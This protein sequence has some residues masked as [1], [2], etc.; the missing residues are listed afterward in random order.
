MTNLLDKEWEQS[1][2]KA[3]DSKFSKIYHSV[4]FNELDIKRYCKKDSK[5]LEIGCGNG[6]NLMKLK[7]IGYEDIWG[8]DKVNQMKGPLSL[9]YLDYVHTKFDVI[10]YYETL[11]HIDTTLTELRK[12][13]SYLRPGGYLFICEPADNK[14]LGLQYWLFNLKVLQDISFIRNVN[15]LIQMER[16]DIAMYL[17]YEKVITPHLRELGCEIIYDRQFFHRRIICVRKR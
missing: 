11:H 10:L 9:C 12:A 3:N 4:F 16:D 2:T 17:A 14:W 7:E 8:Y 5:I 15:K 13:I 1:Y 6:R